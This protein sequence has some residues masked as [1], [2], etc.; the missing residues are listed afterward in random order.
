MSAPHNAILLN[1][2]W[3]LAKLPHRLYMPVQ[4]LQ[5]RCTEKKDEIDE[6][7]S[8][9]KNIYAKIC[10]Y[11]HFFCWWWC[12]AIDVLNFCRATEEE[13]Q[14]KGEGARG[15]HYTKF[16][17]ALQLYSAWP[18]VCLSPHKHVGH[19]RMQ[20][21]FQPHTHTHATCLFTKCKSM[22]TISVFMC[23]CNFMIE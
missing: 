6:K 2:L 3:M 17:Y 12:L 15:K 11:F 14:M 23:R 19:R 9:K 1:S 5:I 21:R 7:R 18:T 10:R 4:R 20:Q 16:E 8:K 13:R 22:L